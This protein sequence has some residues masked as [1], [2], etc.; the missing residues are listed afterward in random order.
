VN[1]ID[2]RSPSILGVG[3]ALRSVERKSGLLTTR[4]DVV[5]KCVRHEARQIVDGDRRA[6]V[7]RIASTEHHGESRGRDGGR[8]RPHGVTR[9]GR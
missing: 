4:A 5:A 8:V 9:Q 2:L 7:G 6:S 1:S 3:V